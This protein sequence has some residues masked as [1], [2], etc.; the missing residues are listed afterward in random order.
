[1][2][3]KKLAAAAVAVTM[4]AGSSWA[5]PIS[6]KYNGSAA[7]YRTVTLNTVPVPVAGGL[8]QVSAGGFNMSDT[9]QNGLGDFV[10]WCLDLGAFLGTSLE[11]GY[12]ATTT[13]FQN[14]GVNLV[15][16]GMARVQ[17]I[18]DANFSDTFFSDPDV[19]VN[20]AKSAAFQ[21]SLWEVVY[22]G[23]WDITEGLF[24]ASASQDVETL[25]AGYLQAAMNW[26]GGS[27]WDLTYLEST[28][29]SRRQNLVTAAPSPVPLPAT[30][31]MLLAAIG[32]LAAVRKKRRK[33]A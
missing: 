28:D 24:Q 33:L 9:T 2:S 8:T 3:V 7:G 5:A 15:P 21:L 22:D 26:T 20:R 29:A 23:D 13:P 31:I 1:M 16:V 12:A 18:F 17:S 27:S 30:G 4:I 25:A 14:G 11:Y 10:A 6:L 19:Q 32:G